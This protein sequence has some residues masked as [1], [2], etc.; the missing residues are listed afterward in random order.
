MDR[1]KKITKNR[2]YSKL[3]VERGS[4]PGPTEYEGVAQTT[5]P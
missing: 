1:L 3:S 4:D 2:S 5:G